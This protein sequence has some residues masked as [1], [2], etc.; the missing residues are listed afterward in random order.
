MEYAPSKYPGLSNEVMDVLESML[1]IAEYKPL[2]EEYRSKLRSSAALDEKFSTKSLRKTP[3][4][5]RIVAAP[6]NDLHEK[7]LKADINGDMGVLRWK[8]VTDFLGS[9]ADAMTVQVPSVH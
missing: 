7:R 6:A 1:G 5:L 2:I 3:K 4:Y 9:M 8:V